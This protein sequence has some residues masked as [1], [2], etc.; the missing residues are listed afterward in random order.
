MSAQ[1]IAECLDWLNS[2]AVLTE[3]ERAE[4]AHR[5]A[6]YAKPIAPELP[7]YAPKEGTE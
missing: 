1:R 5:L 2:D 6:S 7:F 3:S 4:Y